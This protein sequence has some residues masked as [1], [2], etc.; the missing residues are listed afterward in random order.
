MIDVPAWHP[1]IVH[2][3]LAP[4]LTSAAAFVAARWWRDGRLAA[5]LATLGTWNLCLGAVGAIF[6]FGSGL[7]AMLGLQLGDA[8]RAAL[9]LHVRWAVSACFLVLL[10]AVWRGAG[11]PAA[12]RPSR[13]FL[14][15]IL[16]ASLALIVTGYRGGLNVYRFGIGVAS[17]AY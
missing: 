15:A 17:A 6:A 9:G 7:A 2:F 14:V 10:V 11:V 16:C 8:P 5:T 12:A 1:L 13:L 4:V 3:P